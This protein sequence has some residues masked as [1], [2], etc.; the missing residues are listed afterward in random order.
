MMTVRRGEEASRIGDAPER[1]VQSNEHDAVRLRILRVAEHQLATVSPSQLSM[2]GIARELRVTVGALY[3]YF[4]GRDDLLTELIERAYSDLAQSMN[5]ADAEVQHSGG[6]AR[7]RWIAVWEAASAWSQRHIQRFYLIYGT[8]VIGYA[9]PDSTV[10]PAGQVVRVLLNVYLDGHSSTGMSETPLGWTSAANSGTV[11]PLI[12]EEDLERVRGWV[13]QHV[14]GAR[15]GA[16]IADGL[17]AAEVFAVISAWTALI[18]TI[19]FSLGSH[20]RGSIEDVQV[21][22]RSLALDHA[23]RLGLTDVTPNLE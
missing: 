13:R 10:E 11:G 4:D 9:A 1:R 22:L 17:S 23:T 21:Y 6:S 2:R 12:A 8:P 3:R 5:D 15:G 18:G 20:Y 7:Q 14:G 19:A 16:D